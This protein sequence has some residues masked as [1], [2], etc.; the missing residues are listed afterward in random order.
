MPA[1]QGVRTRRAIVAA[2]IDRL[3]EERPRPRV[4]SIAAGHLR[5]ASLSVA[6]RR[7]K[8]GRLVALDSDAESLAEVRQSYGALGVE[9]Q[10]AS[11]K[12]LL[13]PGGHA[14]HFD[15]VYSMG[16]FD[17]VSARSG[18][19]LVNAMHRMLRPGGSLLVANFLPGVPDIGYMEAFMDWK[20]V[21][22]SRLDMVDLTHDLPEA[23]IKSVELWSEE[24]VNIVFL[25]VTR[26]EHAHSLTSVADGPLSS[27][28][29]GLP[30][31]P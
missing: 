6:V 23:E 1:C 10:H 21:Y 18:R 24:A 7:R 17:Y 25:R 20:L 9:T 13:E 19:R 31:H 8:V 16:L 22:R 30:G 11:F 2:T 27:P 14:G 26:R 3:A 4:L 5:E 12:A 29:V 15:F 28:F